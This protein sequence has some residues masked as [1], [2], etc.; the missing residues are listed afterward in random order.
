MMSGFALPRRRTESYFEYRILA[1]G[2]A[3]I[4][5]D[6]FRNRHDPMQSDRGRRLRS[7]APRRCGRA[8]ALQLPTELFFDLSRRAQGRRNALRFTPQHTKHPQKHQSVI[9]SQALGSG[10]LIASSAAVHTPQ[11]LFSGKVSRAGPLGRARRGGDR[12]PDNT[13]NVGAADALSRVRGREPN[14]FHND[15]VTVSYEARQWDRQRHAL[16]RTGRGVE[17]SSSRLRRRSSIRAQY[18]RDACAALRST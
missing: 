6:A 17:Q 13:A 9:S 10:S 8:D 11:L 4:V 18:I 15:D 7:G 1:C 3:S 12:Y 5:A 16:Q 2:V 14:A